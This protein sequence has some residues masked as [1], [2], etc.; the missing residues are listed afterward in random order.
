MSGSGLKSLLELGIKYQLNGSIDRAKTIYKEII[1]S[2]PNDGH[3]FHFLGVI[4]HHE[5]DD[6]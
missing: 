6:V 1:A 2:Y 4:C 5:G 3:A